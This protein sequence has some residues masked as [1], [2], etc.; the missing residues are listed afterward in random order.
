MV[1]TL[2]NRSM[3]RSQASDMQLHRDNGGVAHRRRGS[4]T[5]LDSTIPEGCSRVSRLWHRSLR[6]A[7]ILA[8]VR[9]EGGN[10]SSRVRTLCS[11][12]AL[13]KGR[14]RFGGFR[15]GLGLGQRGNNRHPAESGRV[16]SARAF[17]GS[18]RLA[19]AA[20]ND[21]ER[22]FYRTLVR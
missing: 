12:L 4:F 8:V 2:V 1:P 18:T 5:A 7:V 16:Q 19:G 13:A 3:E 20:K 9:G 17:T 10:R 14:T 22:R 6:C 11:L 15:V 21:L